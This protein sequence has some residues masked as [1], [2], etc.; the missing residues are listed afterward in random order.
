[1]EV[2]A[3]GHATAWGLAV[4]S[5]LLALLSQLLGTLIARNSAE[6][7]CAPRARAYVS[8]C[9]CVSGGAQ[10]WGGGAQGWGGWAQEESLRCLGSTSPAC[11]PN[12]QA[13]WLPQVCA[14]R[15]GGA[16]VCVRATALRRGYARSVHTCVCEVRSWPTG[17][18]GALATAGKHAGEVRISGKGSHPLPPSLPV[19][20]HSPPPAIGGLW[21]MGRGNPGP[22][23]GVAGACAVS[24]ATK[25]HVPLRR[26]RQA[27]LPCAVAALWRPPGGGQ[28]RAWAWAGG[29]GLV[30][31]GPW[32]RGRGQALRRE[33]APEKR[34]EAAKALGKLCRAAAWDG[35]WRGVSSL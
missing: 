27:G 5:L 14:S 30:A 34:R 32:G 8:V 16:C 17:L 15:A 21:G 10:G 20:D 33:A 31:L 28:H 25:A 35:G 12:T 3:G 11:E 22:G 1:M 26:R 6:R 24:V 18:G 7:A 19:P 2:W 9:V 23:L 4:E 13:A 29:V